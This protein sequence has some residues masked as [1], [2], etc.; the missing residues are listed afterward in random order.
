VEIKQVKI[1]SS[2]INRR[3]TNKLIGFTLIE[4]LVVIAIVALLLAILLPSLSMAKVSAK[5][6]TCGSNL[7]QLSLAWMTYLDNYDGY[8]YQGIRANLD[9]GGWRGLKNWWPR[10]LNKYVGFSDPN[11]VN[12][13]SAKVFCCPADRGG[14]PGAFL[15]EKAY[16]VNGTSYQ[17]NIFLIGQDRCGA[18]SEKTK[19][20]D[21]GISQRLTNLNRSS[22]A[23][24]SV[25][26][27]IGDFGWINQWNPTPLPQQEWKELAEW[28]GKADYH[29]MAF[30]DGHVNFQ[31]IRKGFYVTSEYWVLPFQELYSLAI[32]VQGPVQ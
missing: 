13:D 29:N 24:P 15:R 31:K 3:R 21:Q 16:R 25:V 4:L 6:I 8:F 2:K 23:N 30:L 18:F 14:V 19:I 28:H 22:V 17:T 5:R 27:L 11:G 10:P 26:L 12:Q 7:K 1:L 20:L 32:E 9:Y